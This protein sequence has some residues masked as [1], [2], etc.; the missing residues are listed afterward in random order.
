MLYT[1]AIRC[2]CWQSH[3]QLSC[4]FCMWIASSMQCV[5]KMLLNYKITQ[6]SCAVMMLNILHGLATRFTS[7]NTTHILI[8]V[9]ASIDYECELNSLKHANT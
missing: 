8:R 7:N 9:T 2:I 1:L 5:A 4:E 6:Q 3:A